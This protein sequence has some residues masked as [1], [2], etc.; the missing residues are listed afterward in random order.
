MTSSLRHNNVITVE[1][2][3]QFLPNFADQNKKSL[4]TFLN[5]KKQQIND[6]N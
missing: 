6:I 1:I 5:L 3:D 4:E 2:L